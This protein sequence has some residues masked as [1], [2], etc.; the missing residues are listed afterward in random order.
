M[1]HKFLLFIL[2]ACFLLIPHCTSKVWAEGSVL[3]ADD[4]SGDLSKWQDIRGNPENWQIVDGQLEANVATPFTLSELIPKDEYWDKSISDY[5][6]SLD[7]TPIRG[8]DRNISFSVVDVKNWIEF[9]FVGSLVELTKVQN[10]KNVWRKTSSYG[11]QTNQTYHITIIQNQ[12][13]V[14]LTIDDQTVFDEL[15]P[16]FISIVGKIGV[17]AGTGSV[18]PTVVRIDNVLVTSLSPVEP[19]PTPSLLE[20]LK[21][22]DPIWA[23]EEYDS[24]TNWSENPTI[25]RWGCALTSLVMVLKSHGINQLPGDVDLTPIT[26]NDWL[27][28]QP[29]GYLKN[30]ILNWISATRLSW[31]LADIYQTPKLEYTKQILEPLAT[32]IS[33]IENQRPVILQIPGHFFS[34][35]GVSDDQ[36]DLMIKDP[37]LDYTLFSQHQTDLSATLTF[38]PSQ[39]DLSYLLLAVSPNLEISLINAEEEDVTENHRSLEYLTDFSDP[40]T[41]S[42]TLQIIEIPKP[43]EGI[44]TLMISGSELDNFDLQVWAYD[45]AGNLS[46]LSQIGLVGAIPQSYNLNFSKQTPSSITRTTTFEDVQLVLASFQIPDQLTSF[47]SFIIINRLIEFAISSYPQHALRYQNL[48][49]QNIEDQSSK[50]DGLA[51]DYLL[52]ELMAVETN[53]LAI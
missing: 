15:D 51:K 28:A 48:I 34:A 40:Q 3:F 27:K 29:D 47:S 18:Y 17:K 12:D 14:T 5:A 25:G 20:S 16:T 9:H 37:L 42:P 4:F 24:A 23:D 30:G 39:T 13:R 32:A 10:G 7:L 11:F 22:T 50:F 46:D 33:E 21:Q 2:L 35:D 38:T 6:Y 1:S 52:Q 43:T 45:Q 44:Y 8:A 41:N 31:Q 53:P 36:T 49:S 19:E 26:L